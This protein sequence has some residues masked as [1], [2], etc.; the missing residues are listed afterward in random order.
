M[1]SH[2]CWGSVVESAVSFRHRE[3]G[4]IIRNAGTDSWDAARAPPHG[5][6]YLFMLR[7]PE[8]YGEFAATAC[9]N[10]LLG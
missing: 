1:Q 8:S 7:Q 6:V 3:P 10:M 2:T 4:P 5:W 9:S